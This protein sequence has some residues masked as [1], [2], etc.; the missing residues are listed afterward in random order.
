MIINLNSD[1]EDIA[2]LGA[3]ARNL[4]AL[5]KAG[6]NVPPAF[7]VLDSVYVDFVE[8]LLQ[9]I[10][11]ALRDG[12]VTAPES[13]EKII[14][15]GSF[16]APFLSALEKA[17]G[18]FADDD[19]FAVRSS[20]RPF[21]HGAKTE[22]DSG[23]SAMAGQFESFLM[24]AK[25]DVPKA[26]KR[27][28]SSLYKAR[29]LGLLDEDE[30]EE[31]VR[32]T[33]TVVVQ[34]MVTATHSAVVMTR[35]PLDPREVLGIE[36]TYGACEALVSG[37]VTGDL[38]LVDRQSHKVIHSEIGSKR[39]EIVHESSPGLLSYG[40]WIPVEANKRNRVCLSPSQTRAIVGVALKIEDHFGAPQ[41]IEMV[42]TNDTIFV[43]QARP[44]TTSVHP[45]KM[46][47]TK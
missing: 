43:V 5:L 46:Q 3:K 29:S 1:S 2:K 21:R 37:K 12:I 28:W 13:I 23:N 47:A 41:D 42:L 9:R 7:A 33:M 22:E 32:S 15:N 11:M 36:A 27:C 25:D 14:D 45:A 20:A 4:A 17:L 8:P 30:I 10:R 44:I 6:E 24:V 18:E 31:Y 16:P 39:L 19:Q 38:L 34:K 35:D 26:I 40:Q